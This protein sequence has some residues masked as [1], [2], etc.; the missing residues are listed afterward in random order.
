MASTTAGS[1][2]KPGGQ[3]GRR[4]GLQRR[5][6]RETFQSSALAQ[7]GFEL[8]DETRRDEGIEDQ[9]A[10]S[11]GAGSGSGHCERTGANDD[12]WASRG[13]APARPQR[14]LA[15]PPRRPCQNRSTSGSACFTTNEFRAGRRRL[16][17]GGVVGRRGPAAQ[18]EAERARGRSN[19]AQRGHDGRAREWTW[20]L[21]RAFPTGPEAADAQWIE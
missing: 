9:F 21:A 7:A 11:R 19:D 4:S 3:A 18:G 16:A 12:E 10:G 14:C 17:G 8:G 20:A 15:G 1:V 5:Y 13:N 6:R 2:R